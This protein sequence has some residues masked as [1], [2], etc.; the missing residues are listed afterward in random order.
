MLSILLSAVLTS[1]APLTEVPTQSENKQIILDVFAAFETKD[2][3]TLE[4]YFAQEGDIIIGLN[5]RKR[6]GPY[7]NFR[8]AAPFPGSLENVSVTIE[9][10]FAEGSNVAIQSVIC[11]EHAVE[12]LGYAPTG[13]QLCGRYTNLYLLK[14]GLIVSNTVGVYRDQLIE[15]LEEN[16]ND[17]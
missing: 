6:G 13:K 15:Q 3:D 16:A 4:K 10:I 14:D 7:T 17:N 5:S 9:N 11:G 2:L 8:D 12:L 1:V